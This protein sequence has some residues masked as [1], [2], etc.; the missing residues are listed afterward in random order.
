MDITA[1]GISHNPVNSFKYL[2]RVLLAVGKYWPVVVNNLCRARKKWA[3]L[4][5]VLRREGADART[6]SQIYLAV[7]Q[8]FML[9]GSEMWV[10][11]PPIC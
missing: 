3:W 10:I 5:R 4:T 8:S 2:G 7:G 11:T 6:L 1:Y 9:Y